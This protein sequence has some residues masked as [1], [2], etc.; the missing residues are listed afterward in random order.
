MYL[1]GKPLLTVR[2][3][4]QSGVFVYNQIVAHVSVIVP[5]T[6]WKITFV[7]LVMCRT[8]YACEG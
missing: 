6:S 3:G 4:I 7:F 2:V 8:V 5:I 1:A